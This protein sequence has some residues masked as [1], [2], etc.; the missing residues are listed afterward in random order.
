MK[1]KL[2]AWKQLYFYLEK[3]TYI[4]YNIQYK[5]NVNILYLRN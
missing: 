4:D 3:Y 2:L 5:Y 1:R